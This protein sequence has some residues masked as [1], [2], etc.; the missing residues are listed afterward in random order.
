MMFDVFSTLDVAETCRATSATVILSF[1]QAY[2]KKY[3]F[4]VYA[5][6]WLIVCGDV[7]I[8]PGPANNPVKGHLSIF[9]LNTRSVNN[10]LNALEDIVA[11]Y[12][13]VCVTENHLDANIDT[14]DICI[15]GFSKSFR[16]DRTC[17]GGGILIYVYDCLFANRVNDLFHMC[18]STF[19]S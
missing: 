19:F 1:L 12:D 4:F 5:N 7:E 9:P 15:P 3:I 2:S 8:N 13:I 16:S 18:S 17:T 6:L 11:D 14:D 10:T